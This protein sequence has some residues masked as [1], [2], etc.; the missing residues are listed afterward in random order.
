[1]MRVRV[2][3][4]VRRVGSR[5]VCEFGLGG[6]REFVDETVEGEGVA[7]APLEV[8]GVVRDEDLEL[9]AR[10]ERGR[11]ACARTHKP[12]KK[13]NYFVIEERKT[14]GGTQTKRKRFARVVRALGAAI[15][16]DGRFRIEASQRAC[17]V[18]ERDGRSV[19]AERERR[20]RSAARARDEVRVCARRGARRGLV[21]ANVRR[22]GLVEAVEVVEAAVDDGIREHLG[23]GRGDCR[24]K[25]EV[26][27]L[28]VL[29][30]GGAR[31]GLAVE[32]GLDRDLAIH[33][34]LVA[35][36]TLRAPG[37]SS[38]LESSISRVKFSHSLRFEKVRYRECVLEEPRTRR[39]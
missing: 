5:E 6:G 20:E 10:R 31:G 37:L 18:L 3:M 29:V 38:R 14:E 33:G 25:V 13:G 32:G 23:F 21:C 12:L 26:V 16:G 30:L 19:C 4:V 24:P 2:S 34:G 11:E 35:D 17:G 27:H 7:V 36:R 8:E 39:V 28:Y 15:E 9:H 1:M 22:R